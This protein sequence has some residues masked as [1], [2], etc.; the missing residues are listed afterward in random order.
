MTEPADRARF[1]A[2][3]AIE[4]TERMYRLAFAGACV[5]EALLLG[6][7][8][9]LADLRDRS[10]VLLL[11]GFVGTYS[12]CVLAIAALG[13]HGSRLAQ[14]VLRAIEAQATGGRAH[15]G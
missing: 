10:H 2:L 6:G 14:R 11:L 5:V 8:L 3:A 13:A 4:R 9:L 7:L 15:S 12:I 1:G